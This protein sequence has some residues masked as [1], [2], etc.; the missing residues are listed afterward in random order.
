MKPWM[1]F[2]ILVLV[3]AC[4]RSSE[5]ATVDTT[6][7]VGVAPPRPS[8]A[9]IARSPTLDSVMATLEAY[10]EKRITADAAAKVV[11]DY[12]QIGRF[13]NVEFDADLRRAIG[14][15]SKR[16]RTGGQ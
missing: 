11:L 15:E 13:L 8:A 7:V 12:V 1:S 6:L 16:R 2:P 9:D 10:S 5:R 3:V 14:N 4:S